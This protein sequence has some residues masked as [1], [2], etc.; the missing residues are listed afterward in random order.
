MELKD[1]IST[2]KSAYYIDNT[3]KTGSFTKA[4]EK[5]GLQKSNVS[6]L[7]RQHEKDLGVKLFSNIPQGVV[8][9]SEGIEYYDE[10]Q[11]LFGQI[12]NIMNYSTKAH[13]ISGQIRLWTTDGIASC[14]VPYL[15]NFYH[16]YPDVKLDIICSNE[17]PN[18]PNRD[19]DIA[20][21][22]HEPSPTAP[23][24]SFEYNIEFGLF[25]SPEY[26]ARYGMPKN[27]Q[28][29]LDN[30]F[31]CDRREYKTEWKVWDKILE[32]A[33]HVVAISNS[34]NLLS[35]LNKEG[36]GIVLHPLKCG[37]IEK[38]LI[39]VDLGFKLQ[40]PYWLVSH[41]DTQHTEKV[42]VLL[43][44]IKEVMNKL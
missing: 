38:D 16:Q 27:M 1:Y 12:H 44:Y 37:K 3:I 42:Q 40:H 34:S 21:V 8:A 20:I 33:K 39:H 24:V 6:K 5:M 35:K 41:H 26:V 36:V 9:T 29:L 19:A 31:I 15:T 30:H 4:A 17:T 18:V 23:V 7:V 13:S 25:A 10:I 22:Y 32:Q 14:L 11:K 28:D 43:S 2:L